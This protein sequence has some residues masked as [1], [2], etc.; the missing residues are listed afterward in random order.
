MRHRS[1]E[2]II[3]LVILVLSV[4][5]AQLILIDD[6]I[7]VIYFPQKTKISSAQL[8]TWNNPYS[9]IPESNLSLLG[10]K[11]LKTMTS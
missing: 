7:K 4:L 6:I 9:S 1:I 8:K 3:N 5:I 2:K 10:Q 11:P